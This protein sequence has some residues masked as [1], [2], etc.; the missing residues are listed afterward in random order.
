VRYVEA[1]PYQGPLIGVPDVLSGCG[2]VCA[3]FGMSTV[4]PT[5]QVQE[6]SLAT[7]TEIRTWISLEMPIQILH[8]YKHK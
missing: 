6:I 7:A 8:L 3:L 2:L 4:L 5:C 1:M